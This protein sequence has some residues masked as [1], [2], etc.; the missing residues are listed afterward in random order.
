MPGFS[1][2]NLTLTIQL[3]RIMFLSPVLFGLS[4]VFSGILHYFN[5]FLAY[6][7]APIFYNLGIIF[8]ILFLV[9]IFNIYGLAYG[10]ILGALLHLLIQVPAAISSGF[11]YKR[12]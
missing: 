2:N 6:S 10:V 9:P 1:E 7:L 11:K 5:R 8:G 3:T 12:F 4:S